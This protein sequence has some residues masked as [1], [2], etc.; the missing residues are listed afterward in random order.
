[1]H[2]DQLQAYFSAN[3]KARPVSVFLLVLGI[4]FYL[5]W[6]AFPNHRIPPNNG[7]GRVWAN[8]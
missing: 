3:T 4:V 5:L 1:M 8:E 6:R 7:Q 2:L